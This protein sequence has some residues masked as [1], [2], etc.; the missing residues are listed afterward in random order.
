MKEFSKGML[1]RIGLAQAMIHDPD[2]LVLDEPVTGLDPLGIRQTRELLANLNE[3][4]KTIFFSS[5]SISELER[6]ADRVGVI[7]EGRMVRY[8]LQD[9]W[10]SKPGKLEELFIETLQSTGSLLVR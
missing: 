5:H 4:G 7:V 8:I 9:E 1:Q 6:L 2:V 3:A 10:K